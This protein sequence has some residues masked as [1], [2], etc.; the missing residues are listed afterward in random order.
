LLGEQSGRGEEEAQA[1]E[2]IVQETGIAST[3]IRASWFHQ[4]FSESAFI[5]M[6]LADQITLPVSDVAEPFVDVD[7]YRGRRRCSAYG[8]NGDAIQGIHSK[9][10]PS[11]T[12]RA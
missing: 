2:R 9:S 11:A 10:N 12:I 8:I 1:C 7:R 3:I 4:N 6:V 5:D